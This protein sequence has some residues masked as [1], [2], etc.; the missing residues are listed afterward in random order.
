MRILRHKYFPFPNINMKNENAASFACKCYI[1]HSRSSSFTMKITK[2]NEYSA[3]QRSCCI[4][5]LVPIWISCQFFLVFLCLPMP[6]LASIL[7]LDGYWFPI[8]ITFL[9]PKWRT[10]TH[11]QRE[12]EEGEE[13]YKN[14]YSRSTGCWGYMGIVM[15]KIF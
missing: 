4:Y 10:Y 9:P 13:K 1:Q 2:K 6:C 3:G 14:V 15:I 11:N 12:L 8:H 7:L 5:F